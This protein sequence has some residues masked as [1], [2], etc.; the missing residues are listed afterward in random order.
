MERAG[1]AVWGND[2]SIEGI[3]FGGSLDPRIVTEA[4]ARLGSQLEHE[5]HER[6]KST[7]E[8]ELRNELA[9]THTVQV[10]PGVMSLL[11]N[12]RRHERSILGLLTGNYAATGIAKLEAAEIQPDW[13]HLKIW[14]DEGETRPDLVRVAM[15]RADNISPRDV[16]VI[17]DTPRDI[18]CAARNGCRSV[19]VA[20]GG[21]SRKALEDAGADI[22]FDDF[23]DASGFWAFVHG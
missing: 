14:G 9:A 12:V 18:D 17:G 21:Y 2:F 22:V 15:A 23:S 6:F 10:L 4:L 5:A 8:T 11:E 1:K 20:T 19:A 3:V 7:Y 13:F 16:F